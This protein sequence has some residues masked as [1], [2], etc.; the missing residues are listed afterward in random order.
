MPA[1]LVLYETLL[2]LPDFQ[3][4]HELL[5]RLRR[6]FDPHFLVRRQLHSLPGTGNTKLHNI[7]L[8]CIVTYFS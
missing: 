4:P 6:L 1:S 7:F 8:S 2:A 5:L 3:R